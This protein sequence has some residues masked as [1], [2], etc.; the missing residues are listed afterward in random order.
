MRQSA[1]T[2]AAR[3][4]PCMMCGFQSE[5]VVLAHYSGIRQHMFGKGRGIKGDDN[6][7]APLCAPCHDNSPFAEGYIPPGFEHVDREIRRMIVSEEQLVLILQWRD[8][9]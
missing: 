3:G 6:Y 5:T 7:G 4:M 1:E 8:M 2:K 9:Q